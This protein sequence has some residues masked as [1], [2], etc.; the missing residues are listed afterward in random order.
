[1]QLPWPLDCIVV[2]Y[3][4]FGSLGFGK[5]GIFAPPSLHMAHGQEIFARCTCVLPCYLH[6]HQ[7]SSPCELD[8]FI[9]FRS[10]TPLLVVL[11]NTAFRKQPIPAK[12]TFVSL[13]IILGGAVGYVG[14]DSGFS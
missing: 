10:C 11:A 14:T 13:L 1:M 8:M 7:S 5:V 12:L 3:I 6:Q 2:P 4:C 9:V